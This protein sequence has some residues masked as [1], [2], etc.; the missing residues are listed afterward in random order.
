MSAARYL[1]VNADDF[2]R[3]AGVNRGVVRAYENGIVTSASL[4]VRWPDARAAADYRKEHPD[5]G[6]G[7][8]VDLGEWTRQD[9]VWRPL[10]E[11]CPL[12]D[13]KAVRAEVFR[14]LETFRELVGRDPTH[15]D[16]HQH[17]HRDSPASAILARAAEELGVP[18]R[19]FAPGIR[20]CGD[21]YGQDGEG[22]SYPNAI[23]VEALV[24][25][26]RGL[27]PG[28]TE[29]ACHPGEDGG[30]E[31]MYRCERVQ[32]VEVL[33]DARVRET[34]KAEGIELRSFESLPR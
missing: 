15:L 11:V 19:H 34:L 27:G 13:A 9:Q 22:R 31:S 16:S 3:S 8:H 29:L 26:L 25:L 24:T 14:Q 33:C 32:E 6:L 30:L 18:L 17:V 23:A 2:G 20:Y 12:D 5:L 28:V 4:M 10:Y 1:V 7:L 21:F